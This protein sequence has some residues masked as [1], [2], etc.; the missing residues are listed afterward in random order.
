MSSLDSTLGVLE[1]GGIFSTLL[2]GITTVQ[3]FHYYRDYPRDAMISR[4]V[5]Y[6]MTVTFYGQPE[7]L[8]HPPPTLALTLVSVTI[9]VAVMQIYF[10]NRIR[11]VSKKWLLPA[12]CLILTLFRFGACV[13][14]LAV[15][16][17]NANL[18]ILKQEGW[19][20]NLLLGPLLRPSRST[21]NNRDSGHL[22]IYRQFSISILSTVPMQSSVWWDE[23]RPF[24]RIYM[25]CWSTDEFFSADVPE[26]GK[27]KV[28][29]HPV[30]KFDSRRRAARNDT[31]T[32]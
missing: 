1:L 10:I 30:F 28:T 19:R 29:G 18:F 14:M 23:G 25:K 3:T 26:S 24:S 15:V 27:N 6:S 21:I 2:F 7:H 11:L 17:I 9:I 4:I 32:D 8:A 12:L 13:A 5:I 22:N 16:L 20:T 31:K